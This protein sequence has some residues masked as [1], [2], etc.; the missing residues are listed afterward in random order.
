VVVSLAAAAERRRSPVAAAPTTAASPAAA[1]PR[2]AAPTPAETDVHRD[3]D[4]EEEPAE[5]VP[6]G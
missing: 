3:G 4:V 6:V 1:S 2:H 5:A